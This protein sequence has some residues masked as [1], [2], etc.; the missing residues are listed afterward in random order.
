MLLRTIIQATWS[1]QTNKPEQLF[2]LFQNCS[3]RAFFINFLSLYQQKHHIT[4][5][6]AAGFNIRHTL[7]PKDGKNLLKYVVVV[8]GLFVCIWCGAFV[9]IKQNYATAS[10]STCTECVSRFTCVERVWTT[11]LTKIKLTNPAKILSPNTQYL[12]C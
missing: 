11:S 1:T 12:Y 5:V 4:N 9:G 8:S 7:F 3:F 6:F 2:K 10:Y